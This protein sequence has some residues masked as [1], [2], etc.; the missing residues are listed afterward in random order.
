MKPWQY[1]A[2]N[3][4]VGLNPAWLQEAAQVMTDREIHE[5]TGY[6]ES[7]IQKHRL[8]LGIR[9]HHPRNTPP[10]VLARIGELVA[11]TWPTTEIA[12]EVGVSRVVI[13]DHYPESA[14]N[15]KDWLAVK[16][17]AMRKHADLF[18]EIEKMEVSQ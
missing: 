9:R 10:E 17:W 12:A 8:K 1:V 3:G 13:L 16:Q 4:H 5:A 11:A 2:S 18:A 6:A 14:R 15:G 7:V